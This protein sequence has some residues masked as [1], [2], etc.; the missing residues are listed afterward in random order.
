MA[1]TSITSSKGFTLIEMLVVLS[2]IGAVTATVITGQHSFDRSVVLTNTAY[3]IA[4]SIRE[5]QAYGFSAKSA[6]N[7]A[8]D[9]ENYAYGIDFNTSLSN[10]SAYTL[11]ADNG[12]T[13]LSLPL[14]HV[15]SIVSGLSS[16]PPPDKKVGDCYFSK[17][18]D[19]AVK[20]FTINNRV[21]ISDVCVSSSGNSREC[22]SSN[23]GNAQFD[24]S[25]TRPNSV[26]VLFKNSSHTYVGNSACIKIARLGA[27]RYILVKGYGLSIPYQAGTIS[28]SN[29][30]I[31]GY[32]NK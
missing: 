5:A 17:G 20:N 16:F 24:I 18:N 2:I 1:H 30:P 12:S 19:K 32:C 25:F 14:C 9:A 4:L 28:I 15:H 22:S 31:S 27:Y 29:I 6:T 26:Y 23:G 3:D 8:S 21:I 10:N 13:L 11:F 7:K